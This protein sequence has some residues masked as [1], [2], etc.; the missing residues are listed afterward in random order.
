[1]PLTTITNNSFLSGILL[2]I[3]GA[4]L[5][6]LKSIFIKLAFLEGI[7]TTTLLALRLWL[8]APFYV[9]MLFYLHH[10]K[11]RENPTPAKLPLRLIINIVFLGFIG[12][13]LSAYLDMKGLEYISAQLERLTLFTY[14]TLVA[15]LAALF[16]GE[17]FSSKTV[18]ALLLSYF[19]IYLIYGQ[20]QLSYPE[21]NIALGITFVMGAA[22]SYASF[23]LF[24]K[25]IMKKTGSR[26]FTSIAVL[27]SAFFITVH[28]FGS[29]SLSEAFAQLQQPLIIWFYAFLLAFVCT[30]IPSFMVSEA[31]V[32][33]G[34]SRT[35]IIGSLGPVI[36]I[37]VAV[38]LLAEPT[39][40][41]HFIG[42]LFVII[43]VSITTKK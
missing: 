15:I 16:L 28:F 21:D 25:N 2:A 7:E 19:G 24:S 37:L 13:Y 6:S 43:G 20:E 31:I 40:T 39:S 42:M 10:Q 17:H 38:I 22:L 18:L 8:S 11:R 41:T 14:P 12:N 33:I 27:S 23:I 35:T 36:T 34:A 29:Y 4:T 32:R 1:M 5:F 3:V 9:A 30:V 26:M